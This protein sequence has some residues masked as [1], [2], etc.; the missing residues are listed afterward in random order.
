MLREAGIARYDAD[1]EAI[2]YTENRGLESFLRYVETIEL[3]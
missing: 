2:H 3:G 1:A